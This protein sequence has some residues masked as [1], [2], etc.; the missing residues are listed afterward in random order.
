MV[1]TKA[2]RAAFISSAEAYLTKYGFQGIDL[3]WEYLGTEERGGRKL[4]DT[5]NFPVFVRKMRAA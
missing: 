4:S 2:D 3:G 5:H 1:S